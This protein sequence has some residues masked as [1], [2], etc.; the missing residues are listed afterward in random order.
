MS[1]YTKELELGF[2]YL[3]WLLMERVGS[4]GNE[5]CAQ[6]PILNGSCHCTYCRT[7]RGMEYAKQRIAGARK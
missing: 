1:K 5:S 3:W 2:G 7:L 6:A 4:A